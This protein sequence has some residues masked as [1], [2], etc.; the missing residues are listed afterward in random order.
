MHHGH[1]GHSCGTAVFSWLPRVNFAIS[2]RAARAAIHQSASV[3]L[4]PG[5]R[6]LHTF[7]QHN[8]EP[9]APTTGGSSDEFHRHPSRTI[10]MQARTFSR[11]IVPRTTYPPL[12]TRLF[13]CLHSISTYHHVIITAHDGIYHHH[14]RQSSNTTRLV[15]SIKSLCPRMYQDPCLGQQHH[16][17]SCRYGPHQEYHYILV[18]QR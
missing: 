3:S 6:S 18:S 11:F 15:S 17:R 5:T 2:N 8:E 16:A 1:Q 12:Q 4:L 13:V 7:L 10:E 9:G 14:V